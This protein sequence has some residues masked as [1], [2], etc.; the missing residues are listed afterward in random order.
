M[1]TRSEAARFIENQFEEMEWPHNET[2]SGRQKAGSWHYGVQEL[3]DLMDFIYES[4]PTSKE[5]EI[6]K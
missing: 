3:R 4:E 5:E 1:K 2:A 6:A